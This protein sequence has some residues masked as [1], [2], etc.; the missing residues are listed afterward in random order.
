MTQ[1]VDLRQRAYDLMHLVRQPSG[2]EKKALGRRGIVFLPLT[3]KSYAQVVSE[4]PGY[5]WQNEL[6]Y[7]NARLS[8]R[9]YALPVAVEVGLNPTEL[10]RPGSFSRSRADQL[11]MIEEY[12]QHLQAEVPDARAIMLPATGYAQAD[13]AYKLATGEVLFRNCFARIL[14]NLSGVRAA[15]AGRRAPS[16]RFDARGWSARYGLGVVGAVP[17]VVF[18]GNN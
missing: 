18:V 10:A 7:A 14:D 12:S 1:E 5:F 9:D 15:S 3:T 11:E 16:E 8:L 13:R 6:D 2:Q 17:A 4:D